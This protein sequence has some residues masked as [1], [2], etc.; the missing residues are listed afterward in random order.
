MNVKDNHTGGNSLCISSPAEHA[1]NK[2][3]NA[4]YRYKSFFFIDKGH[5]QT[6]QDKHDAMTIFKVIVSFMTTVLMRMVR[7][8]PIHYIF[9]S[10]SCGIYQFLDINNIENYS[11]ESIQVK[12]A[13][14]SITER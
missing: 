11:K 2:H 7:T 6:D 3:F 10:T 9:N 1:L 8:L 13:T 4:G 5:D 12:I 14:S